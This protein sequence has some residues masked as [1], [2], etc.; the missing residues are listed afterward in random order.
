L[1]ASV[2]FVS[3]TAL[4]SFSAGSSSLLIGSGATLPYASVSCFSSMPSVPAFFLASI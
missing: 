2:K 3:T 1:V 4:V